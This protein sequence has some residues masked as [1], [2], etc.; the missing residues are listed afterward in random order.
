MQR[1]LDFRNI[2]N[3]EQTLEQRD[4]DRLGRAPAPSAPGHQ[5]GTVPKGI[6]V[7]TLAKVRQE[8]KGVPPE[9][10]SA[11][12]MGARIGASRSTARRYLEYMTTT[13][14]VWADLIYGTVGRPERRYFPETGD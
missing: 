11:E 14:E 2:L 8:F 4:I 6:D 3:R 12:E 1:F 9:G 5:A 7:L 10:F 13:K